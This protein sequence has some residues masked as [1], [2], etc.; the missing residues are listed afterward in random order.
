MLS[1][2]LF[3]PCPQRDSADPGGDGCL[4]RACFWGAC[5]FKGGASSGNEDKNACMHYTLNDLVHQATASII[6]VFATLSVALLHM[7]L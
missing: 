5:P 4:A 6:S 2:E 7:L 3:C 1:A